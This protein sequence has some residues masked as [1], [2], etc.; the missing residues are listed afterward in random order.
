M[1]AAL[2][3]TS[4]F[5]VGGFVPPVWEYVLRAEIYLRLTIA[6]VE[7]SKNKTCVSGTHNL[8][9]VFAHRS[10]WVFRCAIS[11]RKETFNTEFLN[12]RAQGE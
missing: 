3:S 11:Q 10:P 4:A 9:I 2:I 12:K 6:S 8:P 5:E 7:L 1:H